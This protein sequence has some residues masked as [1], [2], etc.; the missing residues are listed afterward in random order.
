MWES[1]STR[2][3]ERARENLRRSG[4][5]RLLRV[6]LR[7]A[8]SR[9]AQRAMSGVDAIVLSSCAACK[10]CVNGKKSLKSADRGA[11]RT[12]LYLTSRLAHP[13]IT[14]APT[15][16]TSHPAPLTPRPSLHSLLA[17]RSSLPLPRCATRGVSTG[18]RWATSASGRQGGRTGEP[19]R[20]GADTTDL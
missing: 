4:G 10:V 19:D 9:D 5:A 2:T 20:G 12:A 11:T 8:R 15:P 16:P 7:R 6:R 17:P 14:S 3:P 1:D 18:A 13:L